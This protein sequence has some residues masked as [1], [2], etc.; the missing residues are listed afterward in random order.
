MIK[1]QKEKKNNHIGHFSLSVQNFYQGSCFLLLKND[2]FQH[3]SEL[4]KM[5]GGLVSASYCSVI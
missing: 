5:E 2:Y 1:V 3:T 4:F